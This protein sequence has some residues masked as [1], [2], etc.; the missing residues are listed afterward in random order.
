MVMRSAE[1]LIVDGEFYMCK[2]I[3]TVL[4][5]A[6][7][8][9]VYEAGDG[10]SGLADISALDPDVGILDWQMAGMDGVEFVRRVRSPGKFPFPN[11]PIIMRTG[12]TEHSRVVEAMRLGGHEFLAEPVTAKALH[13]RL[14]S[15]LLNSPP[16]LQRDDHYG[17]APR[18]VQHPRP[19][20]HD[21]QRHGAPA[22]TTSA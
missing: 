21:L 5:S 9:D 14:A 1:V 12:H 4:L 17:P 3:R 13:E 6:G 8:A 10:A 15:V 18:K 7:V 20:L 19:D 16:M 2:I 22:A 11:V